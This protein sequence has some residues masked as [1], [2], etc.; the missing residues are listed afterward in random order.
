MSKIGKKP[1]QIP[2]G[3]EVIINDNILKVKGPKGELTLN[4]H[5]SIKIEI[6]KEKKKVL[7]KRVNEEKLSRAM[8]GTT[9]SLINN[10]IKGVKEGFYKELIVFGTGYKAD[11]KGRELILDVGY[12]QP[13]KYILPEDIKAEVKKEG[14]NFKIKIEG[15]DKQKV[16]QVAA[17]IRKIREPDPYK[18][19]G[20]R[21]L[22]EIIKLKPGKAGA[23][24]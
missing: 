3:V 18:G 1:I 14:A 17:E 12:A 6:D 16:G 7:V 20:I 19:K 2:E 9:R 4:I 23:A 15:I 21:Y 24:K 8:H 5:S 22:D 10:M 11:L 13:K